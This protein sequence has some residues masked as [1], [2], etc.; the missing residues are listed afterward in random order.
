MYAPGRP[1]NRAAHEQQ[2][3]VRVDLHHAQILRRLSHVAH[4]PG[5]MLALP[6]ARRKRAGSDAAGSA[7]E[8]RAVRRVAAAIVP[9]LDAAAK[10]RPLLMPLHPRILRRRSRQRSRGRPLCLFVSFLGFL[11]AGIRPNKRMGATPAF[12][13]WPVIALLTRCGLMNSTRPSCTAS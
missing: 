2:I 1:G 4:M 10:P 13:K 5:K 11:R 7:M 9:A 3:L 12:L 8:H 6:H